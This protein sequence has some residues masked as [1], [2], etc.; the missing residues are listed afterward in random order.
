MITPPF[1]KKGETI[2]IV[3]PAGKVDKSIID[4][5]ISV[6]EKKGYK[7]QIGKNTLNINNQYAG[8]D[9]ERASDLQEMLDNP[10]IKAILFSRGGYGCARLLN[11]LKLTKFKKNPKWIIG[12]SDI[13]AL[14]TFFF[15][16][17]K[18]ESIH[19]IMPKSF[20]DNNIDESIQSFFNII[21]GKKTHYK[22]PNHP[23]NN[24]GKSSGIL[25]GGN[26]SV[27]YSLR[28]TPYDIDTKNKILFIEDVNEYLYHIDRMMM[29]FLLGNKFNNLKGLIIG[30][31]T[32]VRDN[33]I[34]Y[35]KTAYEI[36]AEYTKNLKIPVVFDFPAGHKKPNLALIIGRK[37]NLNVSEKNTELEF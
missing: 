22:I 26:L 21:E 17:S 18:T 34:P 7:T 30:G 9:E 10:S 2:G 35:G 5:A 11:K 28:G 31:F 36:I 16:S 24:Y 14:H 25:I 6:I 33:P 19:G 8:T 29:N 1:I 20:T 23:F 27:L 12:Y 32:D 15:V 13:T 37:I 4:L 3:S